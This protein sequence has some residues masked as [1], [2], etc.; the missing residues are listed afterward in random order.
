MTEMLSREDVLQVV[1]AAEGFYQSSVLITLVKLGVIEHIG[2][3]VATAPELA[4]RLGTRPEPVA[5]LLNAGVALNILKSEDGRSFGVT[6]PYRTMLLPGAGPMYMGDWVRNL[7]YFRD[8][9]AQLDTAVLNAA[10]AATYVDDAHADSAHVRLFTR[11]MHDGSLLAARELAGALDTSDARTLLDL[12][13][14]PGTNG[15]TLAE[16]NPALQL[17]LADLPAVLE[18]TREIEAS[19]QI[20]S[21]VTYLEVDLRTDMVDGTFDLILVSNTLHMLGEENSRT[22]LSTLYPMVNPGGSVVVQANFL[23]EDRLGPRWPALLDLLQLCITESGRNHTVSETLTWLAE[24]GFTDGRHVTMSA[25][26][27][28]SFVQAWK[29]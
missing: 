1:A 12:G 7:E 9:M 2:H 26:N 14:G 15:F 17:H 24:A 4:D 3:G 25:D 19:Y 21:P 20:G 22:L 8:A 5:R 29:R 10:P 28:S 16:Y 13:C 6:R 11:A 27:Y 23:A 18:V